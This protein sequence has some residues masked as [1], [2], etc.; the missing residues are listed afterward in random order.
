MAQRAQPDAHVV[1]APSNSGSDQPRPCPRLGIL[2]DVR[3]LLVCPGAS[4][5]RPTPPRWPQP[6]RAARPGRGGLEERSR[7]RCAPPAR[8]RPIF[9]LTRPLHARRTNPFRPVL[10]PT[11][12]AGPATTFPVLARPAHMRCMQKRANL[13]FHPHRDPAPSLA[14]TA[15]LPV[16]GMVG[17]GGRRRLDPCGTWRCSA[18][19]G[20]CLLL[21]GLKG[22]A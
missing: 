21:S 18:H 19:R 4:S 14:G 10:A 12:S 3:E 15:L 17:V 7:A 6:G 1:R 8:S 11:C 22:S 9:S 13:I 16:Q 20:L 2:R 5:A